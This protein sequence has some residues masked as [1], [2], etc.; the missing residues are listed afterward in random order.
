MS[1]PSLVRFMTLHLYNLITHLPFIRAR[2]LTFSRML[3]DTTRR[4]EEVAQGI[5]RSDGPQPASVS[6]RYPGLWY[7]L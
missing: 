6:S 5:S 3:E 2:F 4:C 1:V 7:V